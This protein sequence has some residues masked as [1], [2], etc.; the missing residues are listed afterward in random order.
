VSY[1]FFIALLLLVQ[2]NVADA[3]VAQIRAR[4]E[5]IGF[6]SLGAGLFQPNSLLDGSTNSEWRFD[7]TIQYRGTLE[8]GIRNQSAF[9]IAGTYARVP[10]DYVDRNAIIGGC[11]PCDADATVWSAL[12]FFRAGGGEGFHQVIELGIGATGYQ[13]FESDDGERLPPLEADMDITLSVGYGFGYGFGNRVSIFLVQAADQTLHQKGDPDN[14]GS[15][16]VQ[17]YVTRIGLR[18]GLGSRR[19]Y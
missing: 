17:H 18:Y 19:T 10:L 8:V 15:S 4:T 2:A 7:G 9:G 5:P 12:A 16:S 1:R 13:D 6:L 11:R 3:Q 14:D